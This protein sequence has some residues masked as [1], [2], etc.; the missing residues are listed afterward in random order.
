MKVIITETAIESLEQSLKF[1]SPKLS[2]D[3]LETLALN[4]IKVSESISKN[5]LIGQVEYYLEDLNKGH[6]RLIE[7]HYK[8]IYRIDKKTIYITDIFDTRQEP[9]KMKG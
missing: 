2:K 9:K 6:R 5:P 7:G 8:I 3:K 1:L 4:L